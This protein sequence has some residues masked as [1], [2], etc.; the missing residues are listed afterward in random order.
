[1]KWIA[2]VFV[3]LLPAAAEAQCSGGV[4]RYRQRSVTRYRPVVTA[5]IVTAPVVVT[6]TPV[7]EHIASPTENEV[8]ADVPADHMPT[9]VPHIDA[10]VRYVAPVVVPATRQVVRQ[11]IVVRRSW[12]PF[13]WLRR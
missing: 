8:D 11:Q 13:W 4:C 1:M 10:S 3:V 2:L 6:P 9:H 7:V 5:P 12:R